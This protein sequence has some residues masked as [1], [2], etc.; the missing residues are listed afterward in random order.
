MFYSP[1][2][3]SQVCIFILKEKSLSVKQCYKLNMK[4][5]ILQIIVY[6]KCICCL[7]IISTICQTLIS[8]KTNN[9]YKKLENLKNYKCICRMLQDLYSLTYANSQSSAN[10]QQGETCRSIS[11]PLKEV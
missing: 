2:K 11:S 1:N 5:T 10:L 4:S 6:F 3:I 8:N 9:E 7:N